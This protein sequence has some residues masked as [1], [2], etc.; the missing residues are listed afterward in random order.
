MRTIICFIYSG[1]ILL[2]LSSCSNALYFYETDK[3]SLTLEARPD[4]TQPVQGNFGLKQRL[5]L[6]S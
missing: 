6:V 1:I 3:I 2:I 4:S 5:A